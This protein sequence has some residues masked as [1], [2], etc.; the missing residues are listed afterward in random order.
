[1]PVRPQPRVISASRRT[2]IPAFFAEWLV[3]RVREGFCRV[4]NPFNPSLIT[5]VDLTP[6]AVDAMV[7]WTRN[8]LP[9]FPH[10]REF[11]ERGLPFAFL[12]TVTG[13]PSELEPHAP[14][15]EMALEGIE[16]IGQAYGPARIA[17]RYDPILITD[18]TDPDWHLQTLDRLAS[19]LTG[20]VHRC[21][22]SLADFYRKTTR[23]LKPLREEGWTIDEWPEERPGFRGFLLRVADT[24]KRHRIPLTTCC[25]P[26]PRFFEAG[27]LPGSCLDSAWLS[28]LF[29]KNF[30]GGPDPGQRPGCRCTPSRD[31]GAV[32]SCRHGCLYC[33]AT[34]SPEAARER[35]HDPRADLL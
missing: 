35:P 29:G 33:Y 17:W 2:D 16:R 13:L 14:P 18:R 27:I 20:K 11:E 25:E 9:L 6:E 5:T 4:R 24:L 32:D 22:I 19:S 3:N 7:F 26:D 31:I 28:G 34:R 10:L 8:P 23:N 12:M 1:M 15:L 21:I 30:P